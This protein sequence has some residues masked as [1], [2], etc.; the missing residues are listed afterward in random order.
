M[1][2]ERIKTLRTQS[3]MT[4]TELANIIGITRSSINAWEMGVSVPSVQYLLELVKTFKVSSDFLLGLD[5]TMTVRIGELGFNERDF[6]LNFI[7][8][9]ETHS[10][11]MKLLRENDLHLPGKS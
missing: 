2:G 9:L 10:E 5:N 3:G 11:A 7:N 1:I 8:L 6:L 4:Q